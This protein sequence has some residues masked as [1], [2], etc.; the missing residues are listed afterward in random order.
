MIY[1]ILFINDVI[2]NV[3]VYHEGYY[4]LLYDHRVKPMP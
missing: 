1:L 4:F 2:K 3:A